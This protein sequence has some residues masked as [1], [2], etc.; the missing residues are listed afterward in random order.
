MWHHE[1]TKNAD[2]CISADKAGGGL[3]AC[4]LNVLNQEL[5]S[6]LN[7]VTAFPFGDSC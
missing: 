3:H 4:L 6:S 2:A 1:D 5:I 7:C